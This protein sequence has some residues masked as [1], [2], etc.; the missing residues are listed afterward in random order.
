M[1]PVDG[2]TWPANY[3]FRP[4]RV[5]TTEIDFRYSRRTAHTNLGHCKGSNISA[6]WTPRHQETLINGVLQGRKQTDRM[7]ASALSRTKIWNLLLE[8]IGLID[9]PA[10]KRFLKISSYLDMKRSQDLEYR[11]RVKQDVKSEALKGWNAS[12]DSFL[13]GVLG[14]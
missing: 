14:P 12:S 2:S 5:K 11:R 3:G 10:L 9:I 6:V 1:L 13:E 4:F 8:I 7:G